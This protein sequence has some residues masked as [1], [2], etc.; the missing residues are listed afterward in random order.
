[1]YSALYYPHTTVQNEELIKTGLLLWD[2]L[3]CIVPSEESYSSGLNQ[4]IELEQA[5]EIILTGYVPTDNDKNR[6]HQAIL[7]LA[8]S[9]LPQEFLLESARI[10]NP[11]LVYPQKFLQETW[12]ALADTRLAEQRKASHFEDWAMSHALGLTIMSILANSCAGSEKRT[13]T[14]RVESY[15]K[16]IQ[17]SAGLHSG[18]LGQQVGDEHERL[19]TISLQ[20]ID[21]RGIS[22]DKLVSYRKNEG[23]ATRELRHSYLKKIDEFAA[24]LVSSEFHEASRQEIERQFKLEMSDNLSNFKEALK[25]N[26]ADTLLSK[27][28][29]IGMVAAVGVATSPLTVP[30]AILGVG[31]LLKKAKNFRAD[32]KAAMEKHAMSW[33]FELSSR[34]TDFY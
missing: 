21:P 33:L 30:A 34:T 6:A 8:T 29:G 10:K 26:A 11:Y 7:E 13:V 28:V 20:V 17:T 27:E 1:M 32:R 22:F 18:Y 19:V 5:S 15:R 2:K 9:E 24:R 23:V 4:N 16:L 12:D 31:A 25:I 14:D 3:E